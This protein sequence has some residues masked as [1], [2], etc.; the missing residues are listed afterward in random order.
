M[1][2]APK[3]PIKKSPPKRENPVSIVFGVVILGYMLIP[4]YTPN[5]MAFDTNAPKFLALAFINLAAFIILLANK[6]IRQQP[7]RL[8]FFFRTGVG[9]VYVGFLAAS[10]LS[11]FNAINLL[12]SVMQLTKVF[13]VFSA[14]YILSVILVRDLRYLK[15]IVII[16]AGMLIFDSISVFYHISEFIRGRIND[17]T[18]IKSIYSNKNILASAIYVKLPFALW[19]MMFE[20]RWLKGMGWFGLLVGITATFFM[21]TRAFYLGLIV[22]TLAFLAYMLVAYLRKKQ[23]AHLW[24]TGFYLA[25]LAIAYLAFTG[26]QEFL[27]PKSKS[28]RLTQ[29]VGQQLATIRTVDASAAARITFWK[30]SWKLLKEKPLLGVGSGNWKVAVLKYEN[31][32]KED[33]TY[34]YKAHNDFIE[35]AAETG[36]TGGLLYLGIFALIVWA[37]LR[38]IRTG[39]S[40]EDDL[41]RYMFLAASGVAFYAVDA[42]FNFPADRP[43][44]L[45]LFSFYVATA[46][47]A[48]HHLKMRSAGEAALQKSGNMNNRLLW[49]S[50]A[51]AMI[52]LA[53]V[54]WITVLN[55]KSSKTQ[56]I[57]FQEIKSGKLKT[58][59]DKIIAGFPF[60]P[61]ITIVGEPID[62]QKARYLLNENKNEEAIA[63]LRA[64]RASPWDGRREY[65]MAMGFNNLKQPDSA[66]V[67]AEKLHVLK[68]KHIKNLLLECNMLEERKEYDKVSEYLD[69]YL[70]DN[71]TSDQAW[72]YASGFQVRTGNIDKAWDL[73]EEAKQYLPKDSLVENEHKY[74]YQKKFVDPYRNEYNTA[75]EYFDKKD[76]SQALPHL[77]KFIENVP[78][79]FDAHQ[80]RAYIYYYQKNYPKSVEEI[81][82]ALTLSDNNTASLINLRGVNYLDLKENEAAC[83]D[84]EAAMKMGNKDGKTNYERFCVSKP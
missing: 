65:F 64:E 83:K 82:Y 84:F 20:K 57:A 69:T 55:F 47:S 3:A 71:K 45:V 12:E 79:N 23:K 81:D 39:I 14:V 60:I 41:F 27:Y 28:G 61:N 48:I 72:V 35:T 75:R 74:V 49:T 33:F 63:I 15:W 38:L 36:F 26:T 24:L 76:Y 53:G 46:I 17:I 16:F 59:S 70:A 37:F 54:C 43:E 42:T 9:L 50:V 29:G 34:A 78:D 13:T 18:E 25:A 40:E 80:L 19:L 31:K 30:W 10:L 5:L 68:P 77:N 7:A 8:G 62:V 32:T 6:Q 73:V 51:L 58:S 44:I 56:R 4:T 2:K 67:Y 21:A 22:L 52:V 11:L 1:K 66:L